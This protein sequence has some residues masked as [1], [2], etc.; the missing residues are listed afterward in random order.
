[1]AS[2]EAE[3]LKQKKKNL[4]LEHRAFVPGDDREAAEATP[5]RRTPS[6]CP[7][8]RGGR[9]AGG[10]ADHGALGR[11]G[12]ALVDLEHFVKRGKMET[13]GGGGG[14]AV[15]CGTVRLAGAL[16]AAIAAARAQVEKTSEEVAA[17]KAAAQAEQAAQ[18]ARLADAE[19]A[20]VGVLER[21]Q[22]ERE[23][24][25]AWDA[26]VESGIPVRELRE[27]PTVDAARVAKDTCASPRSSSTT[28]P[29]ST[30]SAPRSTPRPPPPPGDGG[31]R[32]G[33]GGAG[34]R[35]AQRPGSAP[36]RS[37]ARCRTPFTP[38]STPTSVTSV[39]LSGDDRDPLFA[40][41]LAL[42]PGGTTTRPRRRTPR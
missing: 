2:Q 41:H 31:A 39:P 38:P 24:F 42:K 28:R 5:T 13:A 26:S 23:R 10:A 4:L 18:A 22:R 27:E 3:W 33:G 30:R 14:A 9:A 11:F 21:R 1:M 34:A 19:G 12:E 16:C 37:C 17:A 20:L 15:W 35:Y 25:A 6:R 7:R 32:G 40:R 8:K 29:S 36:S